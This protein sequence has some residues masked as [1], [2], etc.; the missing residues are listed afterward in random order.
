MS[1]GEFPAFASTSKGP[2]STIPQAIREQAACIPSWVQFRLV[3]RIGWVPRRK[4]EDVGPQ[5]ASR[6]RW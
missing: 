5:R 1:Q 4:V 2:R 3:W 6:R